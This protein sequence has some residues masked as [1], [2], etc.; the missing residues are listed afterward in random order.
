MK[1]SNFKYI[2]GTLIC[3]HRNQTDCDVKILHYNLI[4]WKSGHLPELAFLFELQSH[5]L[6]FGL[7]NFRPFWWTT[8][9]K[10]EQVKQYK[11]E[12]NKKNA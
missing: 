8:K 6:P 5:F 10:A 7:V 3:V 4:I 11:I 12:E 2:Q 9:Y 1:R